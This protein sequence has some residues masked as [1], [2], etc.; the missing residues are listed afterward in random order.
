MSM[1]KL[2]IHKFNWTEL[3]NDSKG[4]TSPGRVVG[5]FGCITA[6][7]IFAI[8]SLEALFTKLTTDQTNII[9]TTI[10]MQSVALFTVSATLL[11]IRRFTKDKDV[12]ASTPENI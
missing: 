3:F 6:I 12:D 10:T 2:D 1:N 9:L 4:R 7:L 5:F 11:G 8:A